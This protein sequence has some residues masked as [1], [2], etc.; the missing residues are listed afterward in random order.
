MI[1]ELSSYLRVMGD[2]TET[3]KDQTELLRAKSG[4][5]IGGLQG[6]DEEEKINKVL[7]KTMTQKFFSELMV[8]IQRSY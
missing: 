3:L 1:D 4:A 8:Q 5:F 6:K 7:D 2:D